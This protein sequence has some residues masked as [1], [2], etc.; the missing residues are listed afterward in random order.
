LKDHGGQVQVFDAQPPMMTDVLLL[1]APGDDDRY[2]TA[3]LERGYNPISVPVLETVSTNLA[4]LKEIVKAGPALE[5]YDGVIMTSARSCEGWKSVV[6][7]LVQESLSDTTSSLSFLF[8]INVD[9]YKIVM[10]AKWSSIPFYAVGQATASALSSIRTTYNHSPYIP[11]PT[12]GEAS[13]T[14]EQLANFI[15]SFEGH[16]RPSKVLYLTGDKNRDTI[17]RILG[18]ASIM[19]NPV[20]V[21][22][23]QF[24]S[25]FAQDLES[26]LQSASNGARRHFPMLTFTIII[27]LL[28]QSSLNGGSSILLRPLQ[29][30]QPPSYAIILTSAYLLSLP[31]KHLCP[32]R[33]P[34]LCL[35]S[36]RLP[37]SG[38]SRPRSCR[39]S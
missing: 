37:P 17:P 27:P 23:T 39:T 8:L 1:R 25:N 30:Q 29:N 9:P 24:S 5:N 33:H 10:T 4:R 36:P 28:L 12:L 20:K 11:G 21:Y 6:R 2:S 3:F 7:A 22:E 32:R 34:A 15:L 18:E 13:G 35:P 14:A 38:Q 26:A 19:V 31:R 16:S